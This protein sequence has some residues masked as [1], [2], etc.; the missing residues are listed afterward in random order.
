VDVS[1]R[2]FD[3]A[4]REAMTGLGYRTC[5][6][7]HAVGATGI[8]RWALTLRDGRRVSTNDGYLEPA[9]SRPNLTIRGNTLVDRVILD[10][11]R[12]VGIRTAAGDEIEADEVF[13]CAGAI[14]SPAILL[15]S[16]IGVGD[17]RPVGHSLKDHAATAGFE[18]GL[19]AAG[20]KATSDAPVM[21][22]LLRYTSGMASAGANDMQIM[23]FDAVGPTDEGLSGARVIGAVMRVFSHGEIRLRSADPFDDPVVDFHMLSDERD[24]VRLRDGV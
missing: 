23:W 21:S 9:R 5:D 2:P 14:H 1:R 13:L 15:R 8:S 12:A 6:D 4:M 7:Y 18:L 16:G 11:G 10:H 3:L 17:G 22:S 20:R 19:T 24:L